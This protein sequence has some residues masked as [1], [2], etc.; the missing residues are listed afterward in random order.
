MTI[1]AVAFCRAGLR[2]APRR[3]LGLRGSPA[4]QFAAI[5]S[6]RCR[7]ERLV[8]GA[9]AAGRR[10]LAGVA[11]DLHE[12]D[13]AGHARTATLGPPGQRRFM[14]SVQ[15]GS[16]A[17]VPVNPSGL[18]SSKPTHTTGE[19][20]GREADE[21]RVAQIV[22]RAALAGRVEREPVGAR[23][24]A[25]ALVDDAAHHVRDEERRV[26]P[27][28]RAAS[29]PCG[30]AMPAPAWMWSMAAAGGRCRRW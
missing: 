13:A 29:L 9:R 22:G 1:S 8:E 19:Q 6:A 11:V 26:R 27:R 30:R 16:A 5:R 18:L 24:G 7:E 4:M 17:C 3:P 25:G 23:A 2:F 14:N 10:Q 20:L 28:R 15:I 21:P 12:R